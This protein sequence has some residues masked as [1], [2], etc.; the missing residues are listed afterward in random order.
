M[1][2]I[3]AFIAIELPDEIRQSLGQLE[4]Q[5]KAGGQRQVR[6]VNPESIHL[7]LKFLGNISSGRVDE[8]TG[9][10]EAAA[11][12]ITPF[13]ID[14]QGTGVFPNIRRARVAWVGLGGDTDKLLQLQKNIET[15]LEPLGFAAEARDFTPHLTLARVNEQ[16][17]PE[18][19]QQ[20][21][22]LVTGTKFEG[23]SIRVEAISL[24]RSQLNK[25]GAVYSRLAEVKL[26][27]V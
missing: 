7:T 13:T 23:S 27:S 17:S 2:Q 25:G 11:R 16:A 18:E 15:S 14:V 9:A 4:T 19:R 20:F 24:I 12:E 6:W 22:E 26:G 10:M 5:L 21:G 1:E 3:R 8:I